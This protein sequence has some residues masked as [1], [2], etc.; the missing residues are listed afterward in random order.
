[1]LG[2]AL[3]RRLS[4]MPETSVLAFY[5]QP[6]ANAPS[7]PNISAVQVDPNNSDAVSS[8]LREFQPTIFIHP[9]ATGMQ[10]PRPDE[11][12]MTR[13]NVE[14]PVKLMQEVARLDQC[15]FVQVS[16]G[17]AYQD[18]GRPLREDDPLKTDHSYA[19]SKAAAETQLRQFASDNGVAL[20]IVRPFSFTGPGDFGTRQFP[21]HL[22][23]AAQK[24]AFP[25]SP[26]NQAR[27]HASVDDIATGLLAAA[28]WRGNEEPA[29]F[30]LGSGDTRTLRQL[31]TSV[32][33]EMDL[34]IELEFGARPHVP[35]EPKVLVADTSRARGQLNWSATENVAHAVW[36]LARESFPMLKV[37][38]PSP[39]R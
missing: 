17:L 23:S 28:R 24:E 18:Q 36:R 39:A 4:Q 1:M 25:M 30:N 31:V 26:G 11:Q 6:V 16:S 10:V 15:R 14:L 19:A 20:T 5:R 2:R 32:V 29:I 27:D 38:E 9:A 22:Q 12:A 37:S 34:K 21:A 7:V 35:N 33:A 13:A 3:L 8:A